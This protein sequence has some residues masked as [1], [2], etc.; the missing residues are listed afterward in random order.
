MIEVI[1]SERDA[2]KYKIGGKNMLS[3]VIVV[4]S[5]AIVTL[6]TSVT[7]MEL[8]KEQTARKE[9]TFLTCIKQFSSAD[10]SSGTSVIKTCNEAVSN[11]YK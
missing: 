10:A 8:E 3:A 1:G 7:V 5:I 9:N 2:Q 11:M 4:A 6:G